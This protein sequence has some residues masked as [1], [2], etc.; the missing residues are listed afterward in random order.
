MTFSGAQ[1]GITMASLGLGAVAEPAVAGALLVPLQAVGLS[2]E[3][4]GPV[5]FAIALTL[6]VFLHMVLGEMVPKNLALAGAETLSLRVAR[7]F[8]WFVTLF[9]PLILAAQRCG[10]RPRAPHRGRADRGDRAGPHARRA[11]AG[12]ARVAP[13]R[14]ARAARRARAQRRA[15]AGR[16]RRRGGD[17]AR[18]PTWWWCRP[19]RAVDEILELA[20]QT[21]YTRFPVT[22]EDL[23]HVVGMV[24]V[25]DLLIAEEAELAGRDAGDL[26]RPLP[27]VPES[28]DLEHLLVLMR[29]QRAHAALVVDEYGGTAGLLTLEDVIEELVGRHRR[30]VRHRGAAGPH[31]RGRVGGAR[32]VPP[33]RAGAAGRR[34]PARGRGR[35]RLGRA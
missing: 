13:A 6:V 5:A 33:R 19:T 9:R 30:R 35:D 20:A 10:Q 12:A 26:V 25:K 29:E 3:A 21:G 22:H 31:D 2:A 24:H 16:H 34:P 15:A 1:L 4:A 7:L 11:A 32:H 8:G 28:R 17:D 23:D 18:A 27:A 14:P